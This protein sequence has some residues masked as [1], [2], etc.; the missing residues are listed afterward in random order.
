MLDVME[1]LLSTGERGR[2][3]STAIGSGVAA[4]AGAAA[5]AVN[6]ALPLPRLAKTIPQSVVPR[7]LAA[8]NASIARFLIQAGAVREG[9]IPQA[10]DDALQVCERALDAWVKRELGALHCLQPRF[11][12]TALDDSGGYPVGPRKG[13]LC[14]RKVDICWSE[15]REQ[16]W[17]VGDALEALERQQSGF[18]AAVLD[19]L[20]RQS[21]FVYPLFTPDL[22]CDVASYVYWCGEENEEVTLDMEC[23]DNQEER[24]ALRRGPSPLRASPACRVPPSHGWRKTCPIRWHALSPPMHWRW[25]NCASRMHSGRISTASISAMA[26]C[27]RGARMT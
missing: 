24:A 10:W 6:H 2:R 25:P 7:Q 27:C 13:P 9:D 23:G 1:N 14:Y 8:A 16:Q 15:R 22:A 3:S 5:S 4:V 17:V 12:L 18:G 20:R 11:C 26:R 19:V 21:R